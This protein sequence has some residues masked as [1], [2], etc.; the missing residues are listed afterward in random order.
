DVVLLETLAQETGG[1]AFTGEGSMEQKFSEVM[2]SLN[3]QRVAHTTLFPETAGKHTLT[4]NVRVSGE[5]QET[6]AIEAGSLVISTRAEPPKFASVAIVGHQ[7]EPE[8]QRL[9]VSL[10]ADNA[11]AIDCF[12]L[13]LRDMETM[14]S[15]SEL[16]VCQP[17]EEQSE[18]V[19]TAVPLLVD[20]HSYRIEVDAE[21][22]LCPTE[23]ANDDNNRC[24]WPFTV[25][26]GEP[27]TFDI[28]AQPAEKQI[29]FTL[30]NVD[31]GV[32]PW[33]KYTVTLTQ[34]GNT[35]T[36]VTDVLED[37]T[38]PIILTYYPEAGQSGNENSIDYTIKISLIGPEEAEATASKEV[39]LSLPE[40]ASIFARFGVWL[41]QRPFLSTTLLFLLIAL[42]L[43]Y[44]GR[45]WL[46]RQLPGTRFL[47]SR[48]VNG[49]VTSPIK[50]VTQL[51]T[52]GW[53]SLA[54]QPKPAPPASDLPAK[55]ATPPTL[56][57]LQAPAKIESET[58]AVA[59]LPFRIGR[60]GCH[61]TIGDD[62]TSRTHATIQR[63]GHQ[64]FITDMGSTNGTFLNDD[65]DCLTPNMRW[66]L[67]HGDH[68]RLGT[69][70]ELAFSIPELYL[71]EV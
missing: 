46:E 71:R 63:I 45:G 26:V 14:E 60:E 22:E 31:S 34:A 62:R 35:V 58:V 3:N 8:R 16:R 48:G 12:R 69:T 59:P 65:P 51:P 36:E 9:I 13:K 5:T 28:T 57:I 50:P 1:I 41:N 18:H 30:K 70:I 43:L 49:R 47:F 56:R 7:Y 23:E 17:K 33:A 38:K 6:E 64:Y 68:I 20:N 24:L 67:A 66:P 52:P 2:R 32:F 25:N 27:F 54:P 39:T 55:T 21:Q 40:K 4:L 11:G 37:I 42:P 44:F 15:I 53:T 61:L 10:K 29:E 19:L